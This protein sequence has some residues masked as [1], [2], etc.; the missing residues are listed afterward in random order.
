MAKKA[1]FGKRI[2]LVEAASARLLENP[3]PKD[4]HYLQQVAGASCTLVPEPPTITN[5]LPPPLSLCPH[6]ATL[7][8]VFV[9]AV[10]PNR[11]ERRGLQRGSNQVD[12]DVPTGVIQGPYRDPVVV[13][14]VPI[15]LLCV[16]VL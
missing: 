1:N 7:Y 9:R 2:G 16:P 13:F 15:A 8:P 5:P 12:D 4:V 6:N 3:F 14:P 11:L 10:L